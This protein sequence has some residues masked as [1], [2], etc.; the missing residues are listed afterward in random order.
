MSTDGREL[1]HACEQVISGYRLKVSPF[2]A[3]SF[4]KRMAR[5]S[6]FPAIAQ[7]RPDTH[8]LE[9]QQ[10]EDKQAR[11]ELAALASDAHSLA[12]RIERLSGPARRAF[13]APTPPIVAA[14]K[15][16]AKRAKEESDMRPNK[17]GRPS[18]NVAVVV[19]ANI[20]HQWEWLTRKPVQAGNHRGLTK[21]IATI[22]G[23]VG[24]KE[25][26]D[27]ALRRALDLK[28]V[29]ENSAGKNIIA[30]NIS[31]RVRKTNI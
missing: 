18:N 25:D 14:I 22:F 28:R 5:F 15:Q 7:S 16:V 31:Q 30:K 12:Q 27:Q 19:A 8:V 26:P 10:I 24:I 2:R 13:G 20:V 11:S 6:G 1:L 29:R 23:I 17:R 3:A 9:Q 4:A 21:L